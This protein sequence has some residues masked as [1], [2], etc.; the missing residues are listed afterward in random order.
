MFRLLLRSL[1]VL[2]T[3]VVL[4]VACD[5]G[6]ERELREAELEAEEV[7][8]LEL[9]YEAGLVATPA[10]FRSQFEGWVDV[11]VREDVGPTRG[12]WAYSA[13]A[14]EQCL[15]QGARSA[16]EVVEGDEWLGWRDWG[17]GDEAR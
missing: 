4:S 12:F 15:A 16:P 14:L 7:H 1:G 8:W 10:E 6:I 3:L 17:G 13:G 5:S 11:V 2:F 9:E